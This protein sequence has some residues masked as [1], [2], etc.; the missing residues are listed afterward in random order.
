MKNKTTYKPY[1]SRLIILVFSTAAITI[2]GENY[3]LRILLTILK[4]SVNFLICETTQDESGNKDGGE[5]PGRHDQSTRS[6]L[7]TP[8]K[9]TR[10]KAKS[11]AHRE[12]KS[13]RQRVL[14]LTQLKISIRISHKIS[15]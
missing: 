4:R 9:R 5:M 14:S 12:W 10:M 6:A 3:V 8:T 1:H 13:M 7:E 11:P 15:E 2:A